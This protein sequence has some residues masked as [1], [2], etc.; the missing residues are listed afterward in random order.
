MHCLVLLI[1]Y[2]LPVSVHCTEPFSDVAGLLHRPV[3]NAFN[4]MQLKRLSLGHYW[5]LNPSAT[6]GLMTRAQLYVAERPV[7]NPPLS[8]HL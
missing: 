2:V 8:V 5:N 7:L 4:V 6:E 1:L 3:V